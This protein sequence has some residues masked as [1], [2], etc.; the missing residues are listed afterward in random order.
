MARRL[1]VD[2]MIVPRP[3]LLRCN[4]SI[5]ADVTQAIDTHWAARTRSMAPSADTAEPAR[6]APQRVPLALRGSARPTDG[7]AGAR[8]PALHGHVQLVVDCAGFPLTPGDHP[9]WARARRQ[10]RRPPV[11]GAAV[12]APAS[13]VGRCSYSSEAIAPLSIVVPSRSHAVPTLG[14][15]ATASPPS[16]S[17]GRPSSRRAARSARS[18]SAA[19][20]PARSASRTRRNG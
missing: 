15:Y 10:W 7:A 5:A 20:R 19:S 11:K 14:T 1:L 13:R 12:A 9:E 16:S 18:C 17:A 8:G 4:E 6:R 2:F 3:T